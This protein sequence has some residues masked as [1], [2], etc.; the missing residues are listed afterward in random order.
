MKKIIGIVL[1]LLIAYG[2]HLTTPP[3]KESEEVNVI[4]NKGDNYYTIVDQ[5]LEKGL[6]RSELVFKIH[7]RLNPPKTLQACQF[8]LD[9]SWTIKQILAALERE[10]TA[11]SDVVRITV[12]EGRHLLQVA[13]IAATVTNNSV[14]DIM[15]VWTSE[16][17]VAQVIEKYEF[18]TDDMKGTNIRYS[19]EGYLFPS[20]Y[21][22]LNEDVTPRYIAFRMLDQ[23]ERIYNLYLDDIEAS[24]YSFHQLLT[25]AS[26]VEYEAILDED[27]L[28]IAGVFYNRLRINMRLESCATLGYALNE[29]KLFYTTADTEVQHPYNTYQN[30]G[31]PPGPGGM[32]GQKSIRAAIQPA[33]T[34]YYYFQ[35]NVCDTTDNKT[36]F[37]KTLNEHERITRELNKNCD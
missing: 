36:Y 13:E 5:L 18:A 21:E 24:N 19:L 37:A 16:E 4:I 35:G 34:E 14:E 7:L 32:P 25:M 20:T 33:T 11:N 12:P 30:L 10:C 26:L 27:R 29:W 8:T 9:R 3:Q 15:A 23:M 22:L 6:I 31:F 28:I 2:W 1:V 17:F